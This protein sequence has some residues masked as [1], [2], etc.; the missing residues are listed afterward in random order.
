MTCVRSLSPDGLTPSTPKVMLR[1]L[2]APKSL[3]TASARRARLTL[4]GPE[5]TL[6]GKIATADITPWTRHDSAFVCPPDLPALY[7]LARL[8][9]RDRP[10]SQFCG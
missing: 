5:P 9:L 10:G 7:V 4:A 3:P 8:D 2:S 6:L 1:W